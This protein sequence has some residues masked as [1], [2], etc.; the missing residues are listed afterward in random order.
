M[1]NRVLQPNVAA[2][3]ADAVSMLAGGHCQERRRRAGAADRGARG[4]RR[5]SR[6]GSATAMLQGL[7][8]GLPASGEGGGRGGAGARRWR[9]AAA[10]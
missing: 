10:R 1:L 4:R 7:D 8:T 9:G 2:G 5:Q 3:E 6:R